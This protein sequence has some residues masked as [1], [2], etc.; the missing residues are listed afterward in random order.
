[1]D[2]KN[3]IKRTGKAL[4]RRRERRQEFPCKNFPQDFPA[5]FSLK[6]FPQDFC[7][8]DPDWLA[9]HHPIPNAKFP[10]ITAF[11]KLAFSPPPC[12]AR[13]SSKKFPQDFPARISHK[14]F[15]QDFPARFSR[16]IFPSWILISWLP[17]TLFQMLNFHQ[18]L[19]C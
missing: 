9:P 19:S 2:S 5:R 8:L 17:I 15:P 18:A 12:P 4:K 13:I 16:K 3:P 10:P 1:M 7:K 14:I 6:I 11:L